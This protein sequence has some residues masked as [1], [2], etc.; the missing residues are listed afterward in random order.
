M[1]E[2]CIPLHVESGTITTKQ[3]VFVPDKFMRYV[4]ALGCVVQC[5]FAINRAENKHIMD[6][7]L[8]KIMLFICILASITSSIE[9]Q[10]ISIAV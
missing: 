3:L 4:T 7:L 10:Q 6:K 5:G 2:T 1:T 9:F 8:S